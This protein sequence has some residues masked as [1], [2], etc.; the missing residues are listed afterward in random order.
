MS[1][2]AT[3]AALKAPQVEQDGYLLLATHGIISPSA[4]ALSYVA[5]TPSAEGAEDG[6]LDMMEVFGLHL[7]AR[8]VTLSGCRTA[9]GSFARGEGTLGLTAAFFAAGARAVMASLWAVPDESTAELVGV[10]HRKMATGMGPAAA[11]R[12]SQLGALSKARATVA[13]QA[14]L[15]HPYEWGAFVVL[16]E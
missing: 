2:A 6:R 1:L 12:E 13:E 3:E 8:V 11:L 16:G 10:Y 5:L 14:R 15:A 9:E 4:A 7:N